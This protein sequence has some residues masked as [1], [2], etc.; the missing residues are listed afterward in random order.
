M[1]LGNTGIT[2]K[3]PSGYEFKERTSKKNDYYGQTLSGECSIIVN[4]EE[5]EEFAS[6]DEYVQTIAKANNVIEIKIAS[7][8]NYYFEY[9]NGEYYFYITVR[10]NDNYY[11]RI[12]FYCSEED[13]SK[14]K[15]DFAQWSITIKLNQK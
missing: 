8:D 1:S 9:K 4:H 2:I 10:Q 5:K 14:Y 13:W 6:L 7:D 15:E 3:L 12:T 11:Y